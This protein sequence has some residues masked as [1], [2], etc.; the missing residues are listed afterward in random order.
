MFEDCWWLFD[1]KEKKMFAL[2]SE[3]GASWWQTQILAKQK[4]LQALWNEFCVFKTFMTQETTR[5]G[6][7][8]PVS[9]R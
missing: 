2:A 8:A 6:I 5:N 4:K 1:K 7:D 3:S 9:V